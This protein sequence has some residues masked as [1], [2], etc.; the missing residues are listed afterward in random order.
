M[1]FSLFYFDGD[2]TGAKPDK[3]KLL[4]E[5]AKFGDRNNF[6]AIWTPERHFHAFGFSGSCPHT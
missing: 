4:I 1:Q 5:S 2:G 3:Y 6:T